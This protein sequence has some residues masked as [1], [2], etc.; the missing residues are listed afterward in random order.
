[1]SQELKPGTPLLHYRVVSKI[2]AGGMGEVYLAEDT[3]L[4]RKVALKVLPAEVAANQ[5]RMRRFVQEAKAAAALNHPNIAHIYEIG[6]SDG[7][8]FIA[9]EFID[10][11][12]LANVIRD[13]VDL[14]KVLRYL[15]HFAEGLAKAHSA[16]IVHRDLKPDNIMITRD[17]HVKILD[18]G[19]AKLIAGSN[20]VSGASEDSSRV[21][22][23]ILPHQ[24]TPG[25]IMGT[26]GYM[27]PEQAQGKTD[28]IDQRSDIFSF[29]CILFEAVTG[30]RAFE[31]ADA[32]DTLNKIIREPAPQVSS[33]DPSAPADLQ[34]IVRRCLAKD[35]DERFQS[36]KDVAIELR[37]I[38][39]ELTGGADINTTV[40]PLSSDS[41]V[42]REQPRTGDSF[43]AMTVSGATPTHVS[44]AEYVFGEIKR[45]R[46]ATA[47]LA[48]LVL[49]TIG[50]GI[51][52]FGFRQAKASQISSIAVMPFVNASGNPDIEYLSDGV[53]ESL[54]NSLSQLSNLSVKARSSVFRYKGKDVEPQKVAAELKVQAVLNGRV[55]ERGDNLTINL[56]LVDASTG[57]QIWGKQYT[58]KMGDLAALQNDISRDVSEKLRTRLTGAEEKLVVKNQTQ[59]T[60]A[61]QLYL[62]GQYN[63]NKRTGSTTA[64]AIEYFQ[65]AAE[66]DPGYAMAYVGL[67]E[68]Y[69]ISDPV[70]EQLPKARAAA[71]KALEIDPTLGEPHS[72]LGSFHD[73][74]E[75][76]RPA[77]EKEQKQAIELSPN[78]ATAYHWYGELLCEQGR[79]DEA[80]VQWKKASELDPFSLAIGTDYG[81][82]YLFYSRKPEE[83]IAYLNK[84]V[85]M[86]PNY[87]RT[88]GYLSTIYENIGRY[89]DAINEEEKR[90]TLDVVDPREIADDKKALLDAFRSAGPKGY[91]SKYLEFVN[92]AMKK[93]NMPPASLLARLNGELGN[94]DEAFKWLEKAYQ[95]NES[96]L[97]FLKVSPIWDKLRDDP[98]FADILRRLN[99]TP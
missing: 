95:N 5:D 11:Q 45:H 32:I 78:F 99:F 46:S 9:M 58:Q 88:H 83:A 18:F 39:R 28:Q 54:I 92:R 68:S 31:G 94:R 7:I 34:R 77:A 43:P 97:T 2:G 52:F 13:R 91:W 76:D 55:T 17:G 53:T 93:G 29:G 36:I 89:E 51:W 82:E 69:T 74:L 10:G 75:H 16:G 65:K 60:E 90:A 50:L 73:V 67:A 8:S 12:T 59:N 23:A 40:P 66:K 63:W 3:K 64:K 56:E 84:L 35:P 71:L 26:A 72:V 48:I 19:L 49:A 96:D 15:Q 80:L 98:R 79:F 30:R 57:D 27:S 20:E 42:M 47:A 22:T 86:D 33:I 25:T 62:Q 24:S 81:L 37:E 21:A 38:R 41:A 61:Y 4:G 87:V 85:E 1:M 6:E 44:S 14:P 70:V